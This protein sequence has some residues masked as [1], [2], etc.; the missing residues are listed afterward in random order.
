MERCCPCIAEYILDVEKRIRE[1]DLAKARR[2]AKRAVEI[3]TGCTMDRA[4]RARL[5]ALQRKLG[6]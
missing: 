1:G 5:V 6:V 4:M 2:V 3:G